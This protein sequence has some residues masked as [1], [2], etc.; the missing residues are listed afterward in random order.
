M[1]RGWEREG[2]A[3]FA[4]GKRDFIDLCKW[5]VAIEMEWS[6]FE[7]FFRDFFRFI[8]LYDRKQIDVGIILTYD[9]M[10]YT[11]WNGE[12]K[13]YK[14]DRA[15]LQKLTDFLKGDYASVVPV[16]LWCIGIE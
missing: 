11:R 9:E 4:G 8:L 7:M 15:S 13:A 3:D 12:A 2:R 16:P 5:K 6:R 14:S 10:A 1:A